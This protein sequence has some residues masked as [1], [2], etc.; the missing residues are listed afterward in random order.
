MLGY[1][2]NQSEKSGN[3]FVNFEY[4]GLFPIISTEIS[5]GKRAS[6]YYEI[7]SYRD[8][9]GQII[10]QDTVS[11]PYSWSENKLGINTRVPINLSRGAYFSLLQPEIRYSVT[12][13]N[14]NSTTPSG[15]ING[16]LKTL[17]YRF[18]FHHIKRRSY[19]ALLPPFGVVTDINFRHSPEGK[20]RA[21]SLLAFQLRAYLPGFSTNDGFTVFSGVQIRKKAGKYSFS[22]VVRMPRGFQPVNNNQLLSFSGAYTTPL[23]YPDVN[24]GKY[25]YLRRLSSSFFV[26]YAELKGNTL[27]NGEISGTFSKQISSLGV[28]LTADINLL[29]L[30]APANAGLRTIYIPERKGVVFE[31][32]FSV[33]FT[34]F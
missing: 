26:D 9:S 32:L 17:M 33:D 25:V 1:K 21:D 13:Y 28:D 34:S 5:T 2:W 24:L 18:Y 12:Q 22:D 14:H 19:K 29:R 15:F 31:F 3:Y 6:E 4:R 10:K 30:Y 27:S 11:K 23:L 7:T 8:Q 20:N 16:N